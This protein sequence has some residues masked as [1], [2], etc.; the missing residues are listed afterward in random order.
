MYSDRRDRGELARAVAEEH[1]REVEGA[2]TD[3]AAHLVVEQVDERAL[4]V[5]GSADR[6]IAHFD[7]AVEVFE[8]RDELRI[9]RRERLGKVAVL[10]ARADAAADAEAHRLSHIPAPHVGGGLLD[11]GKERVDRL[12]ELIAHH[13]EV[14]GLQYAVCSLSRDHDFLLILRF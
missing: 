7:G 3:E 13:A 11:L 9:A 10:R 8:G 5:F 1:A 12:V 14:V 2:R 4:V 6:L